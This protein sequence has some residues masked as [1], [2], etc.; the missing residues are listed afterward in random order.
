MCRRDN[1]QNLL[2]FSDYFTNIY[3]YIYNFIPKFIPKT[4]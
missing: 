1:E 2:L 3:I 4:K